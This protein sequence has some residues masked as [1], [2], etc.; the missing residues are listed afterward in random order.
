MLNLVTFQV[1]VDG[2]S[3]SAALVPEDPAFCRTGFRIRVIAAGVEELV[4][5]GPVTSLPFKFKDPVS[6]FHPH[7]SRYAAGGAFLQ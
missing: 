4:V 7:G 6:R 3:P 1:H 5:D 2:M